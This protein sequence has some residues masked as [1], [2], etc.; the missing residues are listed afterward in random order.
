M[1]MKHMV[2]VLSSMVGV[3]CAWVGAV[4]FIGGCGGGGGVQYPPQ[5]AVNDLN[6]VKMEWQ[7]ELQDFA[8][9]EFVFPGY[10]E[11]FRINQ[12]SAMPPDKEPWRY[13]EFMVD[14]KVYQLLGKND[15]V[16]IATEGRKVKKIPLPRYVYWMKIYS[17]QWNS[18][19]YIVLYL[20]L[21][22]TSNTSALI[23]LDKQ[24]VVRYQEY[25][26]CALSVGV[27]E[28]PQFGSFLFI[29]TNPYYFS[30]GENGERIRNT[31]NGK[32]LYYVP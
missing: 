15:G 23:V 19:E 18:S 17:I 24:M 1:K 22:T 16:V 12:E 6:L 9:S 13:Q 11:F 3:S 2:W 25:L 31:I 10:K 7:P 27:G 30:W 29:E 26:P 4:F 20:H 32:W 5:L 14:G 28:H 8:T 21:Q